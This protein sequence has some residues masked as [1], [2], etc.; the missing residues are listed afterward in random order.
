M[1]LIFTTLCL[2]T[3]ISY[4]GAQDLIIK[5]DN[6]G[7]KVKVL[8]TAGGKITYKLYDNQDGPDQEMDLDEV[9]MVVYENGS[10]QSYYKDISEEEEKQSSETIS[11][12]K[13]EHGRR[14]LTQLGYPLF[15]RENAGDY[16]NAFRHGLILSKGYIKD[17]RPLGFL[18]EVQ[19]NV[20]RQQFLDEEEVM[21]EHYNVMFSLMF[22]MMIKFYKS[23][24]FLVYG[25]IAG[26]GVAV[27]SVLKEPGSFFEYDITKF[28]Y[29]YNL[30]AGVNYKLGK[31]FGLFA[32]GGYSRIQFAQAGISFMID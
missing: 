11:G 18:T 8:K 32:E 13:G 12:K 6:N 24:K 21:L 19:L 14:S 3:I 25:K 2:T 22:G 31:K 26:G 4:A 20:F 16:S 15:Y 1:K 5:K 7:L 27:N 9:L 30:A 28:D 17:D 10:W 23:K 29:N